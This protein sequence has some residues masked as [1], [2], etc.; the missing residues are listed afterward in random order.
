MKGFDPIDDNPDHALTFKEWSS[1][2]YW[3][4]KGSKAHDFDPNGEA[5]FLPCQVRESFQ[6]QG[7]Y[8][9]EPSRTCNARPPKDGVVRNWDDMVGY[10]KLLPGAGSPTF[11][12]SPL[13][14][15]FFAAADKHGVMDELLNDGYDF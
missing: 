6:S 1:S 14:S 13:E 10:A 8:S 11:S 9:R 15:H 3:I 5:R 7:G 2:G 4:K 12:L